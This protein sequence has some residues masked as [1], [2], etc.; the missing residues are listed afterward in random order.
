MAEREVAAVVHE[1]ARVDAR[2]ERG[3]RRVR[4]RAEQGDRDSAADH[5]GGVERPARVGRQPAGP[6]QRRLAD[7]SGHRVAGLVDELGDEE[8]IPRRQRIDPARVAADGCRQRGDGGLRQTRRRDP[9]RRGCGGEVAGHGAQLVGRTE[10]VVAIG[11]D[12]DERQVLD[13]TRQ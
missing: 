2:L 10:L 9:D 3:R 5:G 13:P 8:R 4:D 11:H 6:R 7:G 12:Q 1:D